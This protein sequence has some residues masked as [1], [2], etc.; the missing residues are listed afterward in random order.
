M[1]TNDWFD[2]ARSC[3]YFTGTGKWSV[4]GAL[5]LFQ[6]ENLRKKLMKIVNQRHCLIIPNKSKWTLFYPLL[7]IYTQITLML[8]SNWNLKYFA[9]FIKPA[10]TNSMLSKSLKWSCNRPNKC[11]QNSKTYVERTFKLSTAILRPDVRFRGEDEFADEHPLLVLPPPRWRAVVHS[12]RWSRMFWTPCENSAFH[13]FVLVV[14]GTFFCV[15]LQICERFVKISGKSS[16]IRETHRKATKH[17]AKPW[18]TVVPAADLTLSNG[19]NLV[20]T[21][22]LRKVLQY[23]PVSACAGTWCDQ[24]CHG[25]HTCSRRQLYKVLLDFPNKQT[26]K[27]HTIPTFSGQHILICVSVCVCVF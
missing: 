9:V 16:A 1:N 19:R 7:I 4:F 2:L 14:S 27:T 20:Q 18:E 5:E 21:V 10:W 17:C 24:S 3:L 8:N 11:V 22:A 12:S 13:S 6:W 23:L 26:K 25:A 15:L